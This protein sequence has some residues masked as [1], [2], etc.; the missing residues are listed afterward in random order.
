MKETEFVQFYWIHS[1]TF[2]SKGVVVGC[3]DG[4]ICHHS[5]EFDEIILNFQQFV[6]IVRSTI[7]IV[8]EEREV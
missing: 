3:E 7:P 2:D 1:I 6:G 4:N 8:E 5:Q